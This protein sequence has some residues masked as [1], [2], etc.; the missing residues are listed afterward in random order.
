MIPST[1]TA[2]FQMLKSWN[3]MFN[4]S[5]LDYYSLNFSPMLPDILEIKEILQLVLFL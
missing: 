1:K 2:N 4:S 5:E 3:G